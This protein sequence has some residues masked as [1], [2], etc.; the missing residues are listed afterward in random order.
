[1]TDIQLSETDA[2]GSILASFDK[3]RTR[4][5]PTMSE[6]KAMETFCANWNLGKVPASTSTRTRHPT[7]GRT[8]LLRWKRVGAPQKTGRKKSI[9][10]LCE[11]LMVTMM[12]ANPH[13]VTAPQ[14]VDA[15]AARFGADAAPGIGAVRRWVRAWRKEHAA[16]IEAAADPDGFRSHRKPA[17]GSMS[18]HVAAFC[19]EWEMD[20]TMIDVMCADGKRYHMIVAIDVHT[21]MARVLVVPQSRASGI[22]ALMGTC[23]RAWGTPVAVKTDEGKDYR[24]VHVGKVCEDLGILHH[25]LPPYRPEL[26][27]FVERFI[28]T[29][30]RDLFS[31]LPGFVGHNVADGQRLKG[32][33]SFADR[34]G[35]KE[36][37]LFGVDLTPDALQERIDDWLEHV[38][39]RR[40]HDGLDGRSPFEAMQASRAPRRTVDP[41]ALRVLLL[42]VVDNG[43]RRKIGKDGITVRKVD[44]IAAELGDL[45][46][47]WTFCRVDDEVPGRLHVFADERIGRPHGPA[48]EK[49][50]FICTADD[51][52]QMGRA[53][54][55]AVALAATKRCNAMANAARD[56]ADKLA[57]EAELSK[58][59]QEVAAM[60]AASAKK[61]V[62]MPRRDVPVETP[63]VA[64]AAKAAKAAG[65]VPETQDV[66]VAV[67]GETDNV[68]AFGGSMWWTEADSL[69][70]DRAAR[71][72]EATA[73]NKKLWGGVCPP[74]RP[75][76]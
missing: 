26:K 67:G 1:M 41:D 51:A 6:R 14:M 18:D 44:H 29:I 71:E 48:I 62:A 50:D 54:R 70:A 72:R 65:D 28:G 22:A 64:Q 40:P 7:L 12:L 66:A 55:R 25:V 74:D 11:S 2:S 52:S 75:G 30:S 53:R 37:E 76:R 35:K 38:Y 61:V 13:H 60:K 34:R 24:S 73:L 33:K 10:P 4:C 42:P 45:V 8:T 39:A 20:S 19:D 16:E 47:H 46:G 17:L 5:D 21:R 23:I 63:A 69:A 68:D 43:G 27:P 3:F 32:R 36:P 15:C 31:Q 57:R 9:G 49:G 59:P 58:L 56:R